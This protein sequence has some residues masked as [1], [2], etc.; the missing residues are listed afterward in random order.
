MGSRSNTASGTGATR[1]DAHQA[2]IEHD[3]QCPKNPIAQEL[4]A[5]RERG[6][7]LATQMEDA[8]QIAKDWI[9]NEQTTAATWQLARRIG[10][11]ALET[12]LTYHG[13]LKA[14]WQAEGA[15]AVRHLTKGD[16]WE[17][18]DLRAVIDDYIS[19]LRRQAE[20]IEEQ[21]HEIRQRTTDGSEH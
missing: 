1:A 6:D 15:M 4:A 2:L 13:N 12:P 5:E 18:E 11:W 10:K 3:R 16:D 19:G 7:A 9:K 20:D 8:R 21:M 14:Q 17:D